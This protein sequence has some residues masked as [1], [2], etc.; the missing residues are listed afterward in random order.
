MTCYCCKILLSGDIK[1]DKQRLKDML[2]S[3]VGK[4]PFVYKVM[5]GY[6]AISQSVKKDGR[7]VSFFNQ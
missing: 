4:V 7:Y 6:I 2:F 3:Y 5:D 1:K